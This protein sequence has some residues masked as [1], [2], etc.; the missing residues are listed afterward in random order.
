[1]AALYADENA[2]LPV[3][4]LLR[5]AGHDVLTALEDGRANQRIDDPDVLARA[6]ELGR[7]V[8]TNNRLDYHKLH[9]LVPNHCGIIT[10]TDDPDIVG[11]AGRIESELSKW[12]SM[13]GQL[14]RITKPNLANRA[15]P[16]GPGA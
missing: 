5:L 12:P 14:I 11:L 3:M 2:S 7:I 13:N 1:M 16:P 8:I 4:E 6:I 10:Y 9:R 15:K